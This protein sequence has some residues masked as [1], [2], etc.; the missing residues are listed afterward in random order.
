MPAEAVR[1]QGQPA[2][3]CRQADGASVTALLHGGQ[4]L[5]WRTAD[6]R[7]RL[8]C[9]PRARYG[10]GTAVRG[11]VPVIFPQ[12]ERRGPD[13]SLPR[14][15]FARTRVWQPAETPESDEAV[16]ALRLVDDASTR[17]RWPERYALDLTV[18]LGPGTLQ[19]ELACVNAGE[20][21]FDFSAALHT[22]L[23]LD[24][25]CDAR[26][27]GLQGARYLDATSGI[28][29]V[30]TDAT[31]ALRGEIDRIHW[32]AGQ[33]ELLLR[34][35]QREMRLEASGFPEVVVWNPGADKAAALDDLPAGAE[36]RFVCVEAAA[37]DPPITLAPGARWV[38]AQRL[39]A[40]R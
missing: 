17:A 40:L 22:Y 5:S 35:A 6:G 18:R 13:T 25:A 16:L 32:A 29:S 3:Q 12:F 8:Y 2:L 34:E 19:I 26:L 30:Q 33:R 1:W 36:R 4:L 11:G 37:I 23:A 10:A 21:A 39:T 20:R 31:L 14:H 28:P 15:G 27:E 24:E 9:S 38:G 7:E